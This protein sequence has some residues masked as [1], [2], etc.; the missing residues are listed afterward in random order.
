MTNL[1]ELNIIMEL[2]LRNGASDKELELFKKQ[3]LKQAC[4][5][6]PVV[7]ES[8]IEPMVVES[9]IEPGVVESTV[10]QV[11]VESTVAPVV[12][13]SKVEK[14]KDES[15]TVGNETVIV[16]TEKTINDTGVSKNDIQPRRPMPLRRPQLPKK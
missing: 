15:V 12:V 2:L 7:V 14:T 16:K 5:K 1:H 13:E 11:V 4:T 9:K 10:S 6:D 3:H 8:K